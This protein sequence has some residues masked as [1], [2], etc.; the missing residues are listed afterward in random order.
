VASFGLIMR[1]STLQ[2]LCN[3][4][5][6]QVFLCNLLHKT[7]TMIQLDSQ[8]SEPTTALATFAFFGIGQFLGTT[9]SLRDINTVLS[10][11]SFVVSICVGT[12][13]LVKAYN[14]WKK[15]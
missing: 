14:R 2:T 10:T 1:K 7:R 15:Q 13:T 5:K 4:A 3:L 12:I 6:A 11:L 8:N 9:E